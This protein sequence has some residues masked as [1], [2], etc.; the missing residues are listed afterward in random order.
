MGIR[1]VSLKSRE[2]RFLCLKSGNFKTS[3]YTVEEAE[4]LTGE[5]YDK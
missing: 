2:L 1:F 3:K 5:D 4:L